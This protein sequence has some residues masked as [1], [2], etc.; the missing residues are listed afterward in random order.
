MKKQYFIIKNNNLFLN[1][2]IISLFYCKIIFLICNLCVNSFKDLILY[3][4][5]IIFIEFIIIVIISII[6]CIIFFIIIKT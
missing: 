3:T 4:T 5:I 1:D 6:F 2:I